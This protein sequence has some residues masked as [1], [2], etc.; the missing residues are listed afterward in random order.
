MTFMTIRKKKVGDS[1]GN[2]IVQNRRNGPAP[3]MAAA[4]M[5]EWGTACRPA[6]KKTKL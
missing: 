3:S 1:N 2:V 4:S 5:S 6:M